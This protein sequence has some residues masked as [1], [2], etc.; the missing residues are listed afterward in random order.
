VTNTHSPRWLNSFAV[1]RTKP[2]PGLLF[3]SSLLI[4][5]ERK[6]IVLSGEIDKLVTRDQVGPEFDLFGAVK[7]SANRPVPGSMHA[8]VHRARKQS[9]ISP[10]RSHR[11]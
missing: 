4:K 9:A 7:S 11:S 8:P 10:L 6:R 5:M 2:S 1:W 3:D